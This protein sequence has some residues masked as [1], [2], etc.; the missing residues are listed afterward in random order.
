MFSGNLFQLLRSMHKYLTGKVSCCGHG[1][2]EVN[3]V[4]WAVFYVSDVNESRG[5]A[6]GLKSDGVYNCRNG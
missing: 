6:G 1:H 5:W 2:G 3:W 4:H